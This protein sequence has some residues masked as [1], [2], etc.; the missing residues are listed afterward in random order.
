MLSLQ[1]SAGNR[2]VAGLVQRAALGRPTKQE[3]PTK[4]EPPPSR[5]G[6]PRGLGWRTRVDGLEGQV[7]SLWMAH[8]QT[9]EQ[10][11]ELEQNQGF[12]Y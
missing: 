9:R 10:I 4:Q 7:K 5:P 12:T 3:K 1:Q 8:E 11:K 2:A 6:L